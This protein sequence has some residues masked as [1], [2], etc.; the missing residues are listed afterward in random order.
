MKGSRVKL[1]FLGYSA[2]QYSGAGAKAHCTQY[3]WGTHLVSVV[4]GD[5]FPAAGRENETLANVQDLQIECK[6][7]AQLIGFRKEQG[8]VWF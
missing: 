8:N 7:S 1:R 5:S 3:V 6:E 2:H 4:Q